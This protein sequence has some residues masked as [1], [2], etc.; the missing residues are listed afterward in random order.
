VTFWNFESG[1]NAAAVA[2]LAGMAS[3]GATAATRNPAAAS[4]P[5][6]NAEDLG[7]TKYL[8]AGKG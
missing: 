3:N 4:A 8:L 7:M 5:R 6:R 2:G 1:G